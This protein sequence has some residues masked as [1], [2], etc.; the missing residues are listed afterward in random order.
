M[1]PWERSKGAVRLYLMAFL[2]TSLGLTLID[3][4]ESIHNYYYSY[5]VKEGQ[6]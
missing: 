1:H 6:V 3:D 2:L 5:I 4:H